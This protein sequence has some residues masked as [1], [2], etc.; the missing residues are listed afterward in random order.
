MSS[1]SKEILGTGLSGLVGSRVVELNPDYKFTDL[2]LDTGFDLL[3]FNQL[4]SAFKK[5]P[6]E[7]V[8]HLAAFT[9]TNAA[10]NQKGDT[11][12]SCYRLNVLGTK[13]I[14]D[15]CKKYNKYLVHISTD[16]VFDGKKEGKYTETDT[17]HPVDWYG[18]TKY[19][20]EKIVLDSLIP[21]SVIRFAFPYRAK[22]DQKV[23]LVRTI[24][25]KLQSG[26]TVTMFTDQLTT[27]TF[28][29]DIAFGLKK[30]VDNQPSGIYHLVGSSSQSPYDM[31]KL[32]ATTFK[33]NQNLINP[34]SLADYLE[35]PGA[36]PYAFNLS[37][38]NQKFISEFG[39]RPKTLTEGLQVLKKQL[40]LPL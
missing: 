3:N 14:V 40:S 33:Y 15:L 13:N 20:A 28:V 4:E 11:S 31:A 18:Q 8:L 2:S 34:S 39:F 9:D 24:I 7:T 26:Q 36:R 12:G 16:F 35:V 37:S 22:Y 38:S 32:I 23:D 6:G 30:I 17:P 5:F 27:P 29:D 25:S 19:K 21:A 1:F 10:W